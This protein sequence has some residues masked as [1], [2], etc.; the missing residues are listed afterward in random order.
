MVPPKFRVVIIHGSYGF[1]ERNWFPWLKMEVEKLGHE[2]LVP[3]F[4]TPDGQEFSNWK[5]VLTK[6]VG[7]L[8][9]RTIL[10]GHSVGAGFILSLLD[11]PDSVPIRAAF[12]VAGFTGTLGLPDYDGINA[13]F[14]GR[15]FDWK[16]IKLQSKKFFVI[17]GDDD[18]YVP[19]AKGRAI[20]DSLNVHHELIA[21]GGHLN[22][23]TGFITFPMLL[24]KLQPMLI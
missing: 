5:S 11:E 20:A 4:P 7:A 9:D 22:E 1:P 16:R 8:D 10:I 13:T 24:E 2:A 3:K 6:Q 17:N 15:Q 14:V 21:G 18:P 19:L 12:L 23:E